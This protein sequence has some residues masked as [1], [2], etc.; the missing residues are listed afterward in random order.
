M[1][2][3][4]A[5]TDRWFKRW[6]TLK[7]QSDKYLDENGFL[8]ILNEG[9]SRELIT[10]KNPLFAYKYAP[11]KKF[12]TDDYHAWIEDDDG[13]VIYD[14]EFIDEVRK[15]I[16]TPIDIQFDKPVYEKWNE[17]EQRKLK[18]WLLSSDGLREKYEDKEY[19]NTFY[20]TPKFAMCF[21]NATAYVYKHQ[22][23]TVVFGSKGYKCET[24]GEYYTWGS[25]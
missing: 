12:E 15:M 25:D 23:G 22:K 2:R 18:T 4:Y 24:G 13:N 1:R 21:W 19:V 8:S 9:F 11:R 5:K 7:E 17:S 16:P 3:K 20:D 10:P 6:S 14:P